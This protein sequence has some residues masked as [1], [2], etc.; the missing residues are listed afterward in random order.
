MNISELRSSDF[1]GKILN[2]NSRLDVVK[3]YATWC[4]PCQIVKNDYIELSNHICNEQKNGN[5]EN[6]INF[7]NVNVDDCGDICSRCSVSSMPTFQIFKNGRKV[8]EVKGGNI[9]A[10]GEK[11]YQ[12]M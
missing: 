8:G 1:N 11:I 7:Y 9:N 6:K 12:H 2:S 10:V 4:G 5:T 3:F